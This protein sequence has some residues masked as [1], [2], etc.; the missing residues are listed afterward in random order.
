MGYFD[1][2]IEPRLLKDIRMPHQTSARVKW[3]CK[4]GRTM[5]VDEMTDQHLSN[6]IKACQRRIGTAHERHDDK[7]ILNL[8]MKEQGKR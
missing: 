3:H 8:L 6:S 5:Y 2:V 4:D 7:D 1:D